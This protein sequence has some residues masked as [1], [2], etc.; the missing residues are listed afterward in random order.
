MRKTHLNR[1]LSFFSSRAQQMDN[2]DY[3]HK[4]SSQGIDKVINRLLGNLGTSIGPPTCKPG[5]SNCCRG[6]IIAST[7]EVR[8]LLDFIVDD[9]EVSAH[10]L[11]SIV[12]SGLEHLKKLFHNMADRTTTEITSQQKNILIGNCPFLRDSKCTIYEGRPYVCR[13]MHSWG[14][15]KY[16]GQGTADTT[17]PLELYQVRSHFFSEAMKQ[18]A[19]EGRYPFFGQLPVVIYYLMKHREAYENGAD[20]SRIVAPFWR[21]INLIWFPYADSN[22]SLQQI[23]HNIEQQQ[24]KQTKAFNIT[25]ALSQFPD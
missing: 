9:T 21:D 8:Q 10:N 19:R 6:E 7:A 22:D 1:T 11:Q 14:D 5:C 18:E 24:E 16:C 15:S 20:F 4:C 3:S 2:I 17:T 23:I 13:A 12:Y 25:K